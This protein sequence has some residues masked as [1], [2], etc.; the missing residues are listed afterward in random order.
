MPIDNAPHTR[1]KL[2]ASLVS[3]GANVFL[4]SIK[5]VAAVLTGSIGIMAE[6]AHS[7][8]DLVASGTAYVGI[9]MASAPPDSR[10]QYGHEKYENLSSLVQVVLLLITCIWIFYEAINRLFVGKEPTVSIVAIAIL[11]IVL[12]VDALVSR[13]LHRNAR[14][15]G[16]YALKA[17]A[18]HFTSDLFSTTAVLIGVAGASVGLVF[19]DPVA[20]L[21]VGCIMFAASWRIGRATTKVLLDEAPSTDVIKQI[22]KIVS[23]FPPVMSHHSL[24]VRQAGNRILL[25]VTVH[26]DPDTS[27]EETHRICHAIEEAL[28]CR[29]PRIR[30]VD[31]HCE[32][33]QVGGQCSGKE[34]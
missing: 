32:P 17:D 23:E 2:R 16:S 27:L 11:V 28:K 24:R 31:V 1:E 14:R 6:V 7:C 5:I 22:E 9:K 15:Y 25:D 19:L 26:L 33:E 20:A 18:Y 13:Y 30:E 4:L 21:V 3:V 29:I 10:H 12:F 8:L 34:E